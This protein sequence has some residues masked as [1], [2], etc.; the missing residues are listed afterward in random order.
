M[1]LQAYFRINS[2][3]AASSRT[4]IIAD[5][6]QV[7]YIKGRSAPVYTW[8]RCT[9]QSSRSVK[10][11]ACHVHHHSELVAQRLQPGHQACAEAEGHMERIDGNIGSKLTMKYPS[12]YL[13]GPKATGEVRRS[14]TPVQASTKTP[15]QDGARRR[16]DLQ[17]RV[18]VHLERRWHHHYRGLVRRGSMAASHVQ[19]DA[20]ILDEQSTS[21]TFPYMEVGE[22]D[23]QIGHEAGSKIAD[24]QPF[25]LMSRSRKSRPWAWSSTASS[26]PSRTR[27]HGVRRRVEP[28]D[29][30]VNGRQRRLTRHQPRSM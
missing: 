27:P 9:R 24:E 30:A 2:E 18:E 10:P 1:P 16:D 26:S 23:A 3:N 29:R 6:S 19:C 11:S 22:R 17:D 4:L 25:Y 20:L 14:P 15:R 8:I 28:P 5:E 13:V 21:K 12:V 7:H